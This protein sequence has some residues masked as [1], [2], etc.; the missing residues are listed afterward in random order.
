M[1]QILR[2]SVIFPI[3]YTRQWSLIAIYE[4]AESQKFYGQFG[5]N[6]SI[7]PGKCWVIRVGFSIN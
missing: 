4:I 2:Q 1:I 3:A 5:E 6:G 7:V